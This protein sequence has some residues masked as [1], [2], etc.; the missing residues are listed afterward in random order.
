LAAVQVAR[1][2]H[3]SP[4]EHLRSL[5]DQPATKLDFYLRQV[6]VA[7]KLLDRVFGR[8]IGRNQ[9]AQLDAIATDELDDLQL[10]V[11]VRM[12]ASRSR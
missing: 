4:L 6:Q 3:A 2:Q 1:Q 11:V 10:E 8:P 12:V 9:Q 5:P 7:E